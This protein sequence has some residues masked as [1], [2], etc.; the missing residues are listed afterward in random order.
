MTIEN[1]NTE[2]NDLKVQLSKA[3][4]EIDNLKHG[5]VWMSTMWLQGLYRRASTKTHTSAAWAHMQN[6]WTYFSNKWR[7]WEAHM[8]NQHYQ[9]WIHAILSKELDVVSWVYQNSQQIPAKRGCHTPYWEMMDSC[10]SLQRVARWHTPV[11]KMHDEHG[12]FHAEYPTQ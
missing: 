11:A 1:K 7:T 6:L 2:V 10:G 5:S 3:F 12:I 8:Q 4:I 9:S